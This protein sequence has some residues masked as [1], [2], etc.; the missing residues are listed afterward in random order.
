MAALEFSALSIK[1][2]GA[3]VTMMYHMHLRRDAHTAQ[4][5]NDRRGDP[6]VKYDTW[7]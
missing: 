5:E 2:R 3:V 7:D 4:N 1:R 6:V